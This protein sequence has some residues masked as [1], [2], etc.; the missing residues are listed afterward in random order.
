MDQRL[1]WIFSRR[2]IRKYTDQPVEKDKVRTLLEAAM[3]APSAGNRQPWHFVVITD[4]TALNAL[5]SVH[6]WAAM[7]TEAPLCIA[8]CGE[9]ASSKAEAFWVQDCSAAMENLLLAAV[10][11]DLGAVWLGIYP[12]EKPV[13][14]VRDLLNIPSNITP[15]GLAVVGYPAEDK[16][17]NTRFDQSKV[18]SEQ[19][20][21]P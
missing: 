12:A 11:L 18:H 13:R 10:C 5:G 20:E 19:F 14:T 7:L 16:P 21:S 1:N 4:R 17:A 3:A 6:P 9:P 8:V 15:L 2:S